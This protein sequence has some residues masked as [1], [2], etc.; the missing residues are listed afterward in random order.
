MNFYG[1]LERIYA[2][3]LTAQKNGVN[4]SVC[5]HCTKQWVYQR[6]QTPGTF[7]LVHQALEE[8][9]GGQ[10]SSLNLAR[11]CGEGSL[12]PRSSRTVSRAGDG[13]G[14]VSQ[15]WGGQHGGKTMEFSLQNTCGARP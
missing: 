1:A 3:S 10:W 11:C 8:R 9:S 14:L 5:Q 4:S 6:F 15:G 7:L 13:A 12:V 2:S